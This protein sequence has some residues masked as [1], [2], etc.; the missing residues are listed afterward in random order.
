MTTFQTPDP[1]TAVVEVVAGAVHLAATDRDNT[2]VD[3]TPTRAELSRA[4]AGRP[5][6]TFTAALPA[7]FP[8]EIVE[9][10]R[11]I[12]SAAKTDGEKAILLQDRLMSLHKAIFIEVGIS[13][14]KYTLSRLGKVEN[15]VHTP[16]MNVW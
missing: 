2:V 13:G 11:R 3:V 4:I 5:R 9:I 10:A 1:I 7:D 8:T 14:S 6:D 12:T 15:I 16:L